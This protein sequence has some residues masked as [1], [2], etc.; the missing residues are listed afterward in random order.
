[1]RIEKVVFLVP[2][3]S[4]FGKRYWLWFNPASLIIPPLLREAGYHVDVIEA[5]IDN[6]SVEEVR[7]RIDALSPD[8]VAITN[9]SLEYWRQPHCCAQIVKEVS[10]DI[11][12]VM[13]GV[14][15]TVLP[16]RVMADN[17]IDYIIMGEGEER[18][19]ELLK[20]INENTELSGLDGL[21][22]RRDG[23]V[24]LNTPGQW[25]EHLDSLPLPDY[26]VFNWRKVMNAEQKSAVGLGAR[27]T[28]V[29][30]LMTSRGC[31]YKCCFCAGH[32]C[33]GRGV[34][35]RS[36]DNVLREIDMLVSDYGVREVIFT[37]DEMYADRERC[38]RIFHG[39]RDRGYDLLW[40]NLNLAS[41]KMDFEMLS[42]MR[43]TGCYQITI[44]PE[45]GNDRVLKE[46]IHKPGTRKHCKQVVQWCR[47]LGIEV[48]AD[49][50]IGFPGE[51]WDEII[52]TV[53]FAEELDADA[54][55]F[56][57]ATPFPGTELYKNAV[58]GGCLPEDFDFYC[59][60]AL[61]FAKGFITTEEF[62][63]EK[64]HRL[65]A[66][67]WERINFCTTEKQK[68]YARMNRLTMEEL[69]KF[70]EAT[71][72]T[73]GIYFVDQVEDR[74]RNKQEI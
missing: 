50:V 10:R 66:R 62:T 37:D 32:L 47:E 17:N 9:M 70:R 49:F 19:P 15:A 41:W 26:S 12:V 69:A 8:L 60:E 39:L 45:S 7:S 22:F 55:K 64:L 31:R 23:Q 52:D 18:F 67:E 51:T 71:R 43:D 14:H 24:V 1:M 72:K 33:M 21:G 61:G 3:T 38:T 25:I 73:N 68:R 53:R 54:V 28:P 4:W 5:N 74:G 34:R 29:A 2:N 46:I 27:R 56:A 13:G 57:I 65:R 42:L 59:D 35:L 36:A 48:D 40:K 11:I 63:P 16:E 30:S 58:A 44:S 20:H 6:F